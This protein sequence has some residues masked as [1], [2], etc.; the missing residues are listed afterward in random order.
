LGIGEKVGEKPGGVG[1]LAEG[2]TLRLH[3][4]PS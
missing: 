1:Y 3:R 2:Q 4:Q